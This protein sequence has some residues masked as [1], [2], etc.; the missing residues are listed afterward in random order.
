MTDIEK[1][2]E[3]VKAGILPF[4]SWERL[5]GETG[6]A[7][8][9]FCVYRDYGP[10]RNIRR[11]VSASLQGAAVFCAGTAGE[12]GEKTAATVNVAKKYRTWRQWSMR[13]HWV[14]R[15]GDYDQYLDRIKQMEIRKNI[16]ERGEVHRKVTDKMLQVVSK[17]LDMMEPGELTQGAVVDWV[18]TAINTERDILG[19]ASPKESKGG[20][21]SR[22]GEI[23]F[24]PEFEGL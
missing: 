8:A 7:Y 11:A 14:K 18:Q 6:A 22:Q 16:E 13:F 15:A 9:A 1:T 12:V 23:Q 10:E 21:N 2:F 19:V 17:K 20:Q 3:E 4:E 5:P 24:L